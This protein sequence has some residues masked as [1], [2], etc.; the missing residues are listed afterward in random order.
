MISTVTGLTTAGTAPQL[1]RSPLDAVNA[2][3][4]VAGVSWRVSAGV[5]AGVDSQVGVE[6]GGLLGADAESF[7]RLSNWRRQLRHIRCAASCGV[8][9][10][11]R[12]LTRHAA[13]HGSKQWTGIRLDVAPSYDSSSV[14]KATTSVTLVCT[15]PLCAAPATTGFLVVPT[16]ETGTPAGTLS[17]ASPGWSQSLGECGGLTHTQPDNVTSWAFT[18]RP[19]T[20]L[21]GTVTFSAA[22]AAGY[23]NT[24]LAVACLLDSAA[25]ADSVPTEHAGMSMR[26]SRALQGVRTSS[27]CPSSA[28]SGIAVRGTAAHNMAMMHSAFFA[29]P[30]G[31]GNLLFSTA[32]I[33]TPCQL[34]AAVVLSAL[35][36]AI[37]VVVATLAAP[38]ERSTTCERVTPLQALAGSLAIAVR[39]GCHYI[40]MLLVMSFNVWIII[41]VVGGHAAG[42]VLIAV[43][44]RAA[45]I[46]TILRPT[47]SSSAPS[48]HD[49]N[50]TTP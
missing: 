40:C 17:P 38:L 2:P 47:S 22:V 35:F 5:E 25:S 7:S 39:T 20:G 46:P 41:A 13:I 6:H 23:D 48:C 4:C 44:R 37:T 24:F 34:A 28:V 50:F 11:R 49:V 15:S 27:S 32:V 19:T 8:A 30:T 10:A 42:L 18:W 29:Q 43:L 45:L 3:R 14:Q 31:W 33:S 36:G 1:K 26:R 12:Q 9:P 21:R 16:D